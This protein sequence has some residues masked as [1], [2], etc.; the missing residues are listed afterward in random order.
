VYQTLVL[1]V[2]ALPAY[3]SAPSA[4]HHAALVDVV[5]YLGCTASRGI[6]YGSRRALLAVWCDAN[7]A[8][9]LETRR[10]ATGWTVIM[11]GG[12][13]SW[14]STKQATATASTMEAEYQACGV[15]AREVFLYG[16]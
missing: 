6:T 9:C 3:C 11:Y 7:F 5:K 16:R 13:V 14:S 2:G 12:A 4:V 15:V 10:S 8:A 1:A